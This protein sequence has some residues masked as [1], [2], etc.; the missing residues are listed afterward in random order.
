MSEAEH[1][2]RLTQM[3]VRIDGLARNVVELSE[4][5]RAAIEEMRRA[6]EETRTLAQTV[7]TR[8]GELHD[9]TITLQRGTNEVFGALHARLDATIQ[10]VTK[11]AER[12]RSRDEDL[13][14]SVQELATEERERQNKAAER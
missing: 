1:D 14:R 7:F 4:L 9:D 13:E 3:G 11:N 12:S 5:V 8:L 6:R 2:S 10:Q